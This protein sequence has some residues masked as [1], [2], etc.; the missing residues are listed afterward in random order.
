M[1]WQTGDGQAVWPRAMEVVMKGRT[2]ATSSGWSAQNACRRTHQRARGHTALRPRRRVH[3]A[4]ECAR[5]LFS[6]RGSSRQHG[7]QH[8]PHWRPHRFRVDR[9]CRQRS[10]RCSRVAS[11]Q[12]LARLSIRATH[13]VRPLRGSNHTQVRRHRAPQ[14]GSRWETR[15]PVRN[16]IDGL[17]H[18]TR[19]WRRCGI[20]RIET[21]NLQRGSR[22]FEEGTR[23][24]SRLIE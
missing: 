19:P 2:E 9:G 24:P 13:E 3:P 20:C 23:P 1:E 14:A 8:A 15:C 5:H 18:A 17:R 7:V 22:W 12:S 21:N 11:H 10:A 16:L 6:S 4:A